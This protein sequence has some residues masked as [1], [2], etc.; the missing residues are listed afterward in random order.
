MAETVRGSIGQEQVFLEN[1]ATEATLLKLLEAVQQAGGVSAAAAVAGTARSAGINPDTVKKANESVSFL[2]KASIGAA[3]ALGKLYDQLISGNPSISASLAAFKDLPGPI[4]FLADKFSLL[5]QFQETNMKTYRDISQAGVN[6]GGSLTDL[7]MASANAYV[8]LE[9]FGNILKNNSRTLAMMGGSANDGAMAFASMSNQLISSTAGSKLMALGYTA[10]DVNNGMLNYIAITGGR[11]KAELANSEKITAASAAYLEE[12]DKLSQFTGMNRKQLEEE[13]KKAAAQAAFQRK[14]QSLGEEERLKL[15]SAYD[16]AAASGIAGATD[17]V[18]SA[19]LG[20]PPLTK[21]AQQLAGTLP[22]A[23]TGL[24]NM[25]N[26]AMRTGSTMDD[27]RKAN[28]QFV[29]GAVDGAKRLG[30]TGDALSLQGNKTITSAIALENQMN[31]KGIKTAD[32]HTNAMRE[33]D[34]KQAEQ[35]NSQAATMVEAE[36]QLKEF[37]QVLMSI[38]API[39]AFL[40]PA[41][42]YLGP[43]LIGLSIAVVAVKTAMITWQAFLAAR[44]AARAVSAA[45]GGVGGVV[46]VLRDRITGGGGQ[47]GGGF[48]GPPRPPVP[49]TSP[50]NAMPTAAPGGGGFVGFVKALG[51]GL[52]SLAPIAVPM[53]IGAGA[54]AGV[55]ALLGAG[56]AAAVALIGLSLPTFAKGLKEITEIDGLNLAKVA[57]G[58][59][60]L[61]PAMVIFAGS[62]VIA[63]LGAVGAKITNFFSGGGPIAMVKDTV[64]ELTPILPQLTQIGPALNSYASGI[65]AFGKA[66]NTVDLAKAEKLKEVMKGPGLLESISASASKMVSAT[67]NLT[68]GQASSGEKTAGEIAALNTTMKE[69]LRY[70]RDTAEHTKNTHNATKSLNPN[71][72]A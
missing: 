8:S 4:G 17:A 59:A 40:T 23:Y 12:L 64:L 70:V 53:L 29:M 63:G 62:S 55:I 67:A 60:A 69:I 26:T 21:E 35:A 24:T 49:P 66:I 38:V 30:A 47:P 39:V 9:Q 16:R 1:A 25:T 42:K 6:F 20:M 2:D 43:A 56:V 7:R 37:G 34:R 57:L 10:E 41:L 15:Q 52:A 72:F 48:V 44:N 54:I 33:I 31:A 14:M 61:G 27:V 11:T 5:A 68:T 3:G 18:M 45:G 71:L 32:D 51:R 36:K 22:G 19:A 46:N 28:S 58:L 50:L 13:Q 65:V